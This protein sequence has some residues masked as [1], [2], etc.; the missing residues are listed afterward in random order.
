MATLTQT[1]VGMGLYPWVLW[2]TGQVVRCDRGTPSA[3]GGW[4]SS[5]SG[6][7]AAAAGSFHTLLSAERWGTTGYVGWCLC[8]WGALD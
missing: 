7:H 3:L 4:S 6:R 2:G 8:S 1:R 5:G